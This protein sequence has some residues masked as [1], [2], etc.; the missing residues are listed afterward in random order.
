MFSVSSGGTK[1]G[2][3]VAT[4][5]NAKNSFANEFSPLAHEETCELIK[6]SGYPRRERRLTAKAVKLEEQNK[7]ESLTPESR[8][9]CPSSFP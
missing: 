2:H 6:G 9:V 3:K 5:R 1:S 4:Q 7:K 8:T